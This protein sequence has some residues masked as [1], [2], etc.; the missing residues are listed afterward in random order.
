V[1]TQESQEGEERA[2][3]RLEATV[4]GFVLAS[5]RLSDQTIRAL[6]KRT[7]VVVLNRTV[8]EVASVASDNVRATKKATEH[9]IELRH[10]SI[11]YLGGPEASFANG[12]RWRGL[13]EAGHELDLQVRRIGPFL[14][15]LRGGGDAAERWRQRPTTAVIAYNDLMALGVMSRVHARGLRVPEDLNVIGI[16]DIPMSGMSNPALTTVAFPKEA[17]GRAAVGLLLS[18]IDQ[19]D[20]ARATARRELPAQLLVRGSTGIAVSET[21]PH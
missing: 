9:L 14:P 2:I 5:S 8:G 1:E 4:D 6:A 19:A 11:C 16:D 21:R 7:P 15:T 20:D 12:M 18:L 3:S 13:K 10:A 17:A